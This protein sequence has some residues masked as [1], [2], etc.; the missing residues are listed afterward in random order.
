MA[1]SATIREYLNKHQ[2]FTYKYK[3]PEE[4]LPAIL[5]VLVNALRVKKLVL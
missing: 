1:L 2:L 3:S 4:I 5:C